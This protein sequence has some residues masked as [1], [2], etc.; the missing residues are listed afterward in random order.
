MHLYKSESEQGY[1]FA[2]FV[3][4]A[5]KTLCLTGTLLNGYADG[6]FYLLYRTI[7]YT[8]QKDGFEYSNCGDF[9]RTYGVVRRNNRYDSRNQRIGN[10]S[11]KRLPGVSPLVFTKFLLENA[12]FLSLSDLSESLP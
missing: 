9:L 7:P 12:V 6:L 3:N 1:A 2:D 8:M 4:V 11:E 5:K 10:T